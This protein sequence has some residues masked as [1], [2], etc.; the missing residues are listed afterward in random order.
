MNNRYLKETVLKLAK[1]KIIVL[2]LGIAGAVI[3]FFYAKTISPEYTAK[4][5]VFPLTASNENPTANMLTN[6]LGGSD[7]PKSFSQD[8]SINIVELALSRNTMERVVLKR[9][10]GFGNKT[11]ATLLIESHNKYKK[12]LDKAYDLPKDTFKLKALGTALL[13]KNY[14]AK[15]L[16]SGIFEVTFTNPDQKLLSPVSYE[17]IDKISQFYI[18]LKIR[19]ARR[20]F[21]FTE[22][23]IDSLQQVLDTYD[24]Q[25]V[26][27]NNTTRFVPNSRM[28]YSIPKENLVN[29]K[30]RVSRQR[31]AAANNREEALW[32]LQKATPILATLDKP[33]PPF[34]KKAPSALMYAALGFFLGALG[35]VGLLI[36][37][38][39]YRYAK[40]EANNAIFGEEE[41]NASAENA[42]TNTAG[43]K[44]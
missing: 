30:E 24:R 38:N 26:N 29:A 22:Q 12:P 2:V 16:K 14:T 34:D 3:L 15:V 19:K 28:E 32:R 1:F 18:E 41:A 43:V 17:L 5:T 8:A 42:S 44:A 25:A 20:D 40:E 23:K 33:E 36:A 9:L 4:A 13:R 27:M 31:D 6:I 35:A 7:A 37:P 21:D 39:L 10:P 11:I